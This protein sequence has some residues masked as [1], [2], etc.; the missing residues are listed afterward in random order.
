VS[1]DFNQ[2]SIR[3]L[4]G[5]SLEGMI[6]KKKP[7]DESGGCVIETKTNDCPSRDGNNILPFNIPLIM[8]EN[9]NLIAN[10]LKSHDIYQY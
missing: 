10:N 6:G 5:Q 1:D 7:P 3:N 9:S 4:L 2:V 8:Y